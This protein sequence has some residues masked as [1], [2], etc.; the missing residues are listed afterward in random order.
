MFYYKLGDVQVKDNDI[1]GV[2][3]LDD[4]PIDEVDA[5]EEGVPMVIYYSDGDVYT[6]D[7]VIS[8]DQTDRGF[9]VETEKYNFRF[10]NEYEDD[11]DSLAWYH[12]DDDEHLSGQ[13]LFDE[14]DF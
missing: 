4:R 2:F 10:D 5:G 3:V 9:W 6:Y 11:E 13:A 7:N 1:V 12:D 8:F 14:F